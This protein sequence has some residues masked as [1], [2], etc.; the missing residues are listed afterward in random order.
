M[1]EDTPR[2]LAECL[3]CG[4]KYSALVGNKNTSLNK[5]PECG[6]VNYKYIE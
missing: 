2:R 6:E 1:G 3:T 4:E 5:C